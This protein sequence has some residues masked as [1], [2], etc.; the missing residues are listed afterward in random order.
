MALITHLESVVSPAAKFHF[1]ALIIKRE[2]G[3][4]DRTR[5][6]EHSWRDVG[7]QS[8]TCHYNIGWVGGVEGFTSTEMNNA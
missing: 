7:T 3:D 1:T 5:R 6:L 4:I 8:S 2:P